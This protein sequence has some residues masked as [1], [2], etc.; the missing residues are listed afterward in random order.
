M[1][2]QV[3]AATLLVAGLTGCAGSSTSAT[4]PP[5]HPG[6]I[7]LTD[8]DTGST[9]PAHAGDRIVVT[10]HSTYWQPTAPSTAAVRADG[11]PSVERSADCA[12]SVPGSGCGTVTAHYVVV[13]AGTAVLAAHRVSCGEAL[14][15]TGSTA[16]W[17]V[18]V[19]VT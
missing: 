15:C 7:A 6:T 5:A 19:D 10:L 16:V 18:T 11:R 12:G 8:K 13:H 2:A 14:R 3:M 17:R 9:V 4:P 1:R